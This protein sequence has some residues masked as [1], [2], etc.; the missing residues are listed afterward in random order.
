MP[1]RLPRSALEQ[2]TVLEAVIDHGSFE[3]AAEALGR[4]QSSVSYALRRLQEALP[5]PI[6]E[7]RGRRTVLTEHGQVLLR[8][9]R[10]LLDEAT[11]LERLANTLAQGV[12]TEIRL[13]VEVVCPPALV[14][15]SLARFSERL[16]QT[17]VQL[18]E[19]VLAGTSEALLERRVDLAISGR[20][21]PGFLGTPLVDVEFIAVAK[22]DHPLL[23]LGR[24]LTGKDLERHRQVVVRDTGVSRTIDSG[25]LSA[26]QRWTVSHLRTAIETIREGLAFAWVPK[27]HIRDDLARGDLLPLP[28]REGG[29]GTLTLRLAYADRDGAGP[30]TRLMA[31]LLGEEAERLR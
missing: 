16:P 22:R 11:D 3:A 9:A 8:R 28:L 1:R 14:L 23:A 5:V 31:E 6:L 18:H 13:A 20:L 2:W 15:R 7:Q 10:G 12:E 25:W 17:R 21:P 29:T 27:A 26:E 4:S 19:S 24:E 30:A